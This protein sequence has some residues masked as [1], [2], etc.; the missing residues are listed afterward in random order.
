MIQGVFKI[1]V[2]NLTSQVKLL[3]KWYLFKKK[4]KEKLRKVYVSVY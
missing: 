3:I 4:N 2:E 1:G